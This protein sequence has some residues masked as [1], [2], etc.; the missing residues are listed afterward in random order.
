MMER[1]ESHHTH[2]QPSKKASLGW[3]LVCTVGAALFAVMI[4]TQ[5]ALAHASHDPRLDGFR[6]A[7]WPKQDLRLLRQTIYSIRSTPPLV[8]RNCSIRH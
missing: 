3:L 5:G 6:N 1:R 2:R 8:P 4:A 7:G